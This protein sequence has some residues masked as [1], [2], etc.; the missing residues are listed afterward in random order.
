MVAR[1]AVKAV[2]TRMKSERPAGSSRVLRKA[3][4]A[5]SCI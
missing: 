1:S 3:L 2:V 4:A 5:G